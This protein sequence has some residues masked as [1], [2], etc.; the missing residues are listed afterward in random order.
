ML[1]LEVRKVFGIWIS[2][3]VAVAFLMAL[4]MLAAWIEHRADQDKPTDEA[5]TAP[6]E[7]LPNAA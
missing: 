5:T 1:A 2:A 3:V 4:I 7:G 6:H